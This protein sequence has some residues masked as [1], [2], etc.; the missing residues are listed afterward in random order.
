MICVLSVENEATDEE[1]C[2]QPRVSLIGG[3]EE[4]VEEEEETEKGVSYGVV[5]GQ[6]R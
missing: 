4:D 5:D 1:K 2:Q 6:N 3:D